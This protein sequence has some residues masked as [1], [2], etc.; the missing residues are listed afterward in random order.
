MGWQRQRSWP[1]N[2]FDMANQQTHGSHLGTMVSEECD[3]LTFCNG[4]RF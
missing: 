2:K 4:H 1:F 3:L